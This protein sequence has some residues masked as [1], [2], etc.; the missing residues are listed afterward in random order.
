M[1]NIITNLIESIFT[2]PIT[3]LFLL[4][5]TL[6]SIFKIIENNKLYLFVGSKLE[7]IN[8][9]YK[10][11]VFYSKIRNDYYTYSKENPY[12]DV[13]ITS[14]VEEVVSDLKYNNL[15]ILEKIRSIKNSSSISILLGVLGT[16]VGLSTMLLCVDTKDIINS[17][18]S[19]ISSM[20]TAFTTSIFG[21]VFSLI[22]GYFTKIKDC[23]HV[24][25][26][27]ML[28]SENL[29]TSEVTHIKSERMDLKVEE[30]KNTIKQISKSIEAIEKFDKISKDLNDFNDEF[31]SGI[32]AL[33]SLLEGSQSSIKTFDQSVRKLDKQFNILNVKFVK[34]FDKYDNQD[35][36]N[37]EI[38]F[39]IKESSK[40]IYNSTESQHKIKDYIRNINAGFALYERSAQDLLTKLMTHENKISQNQKILLDEKYTLD[41]SIKNL[42]SIIENFSNDL[43][44]K[45]D[46]MFENS[47]D[48]QDKL[49]VMFNN[50]FMQD[51]VPL[52]SEDL[53]ENNIDSIFNPLSEEIY[54]IEK[55]EIKAIGEDELNE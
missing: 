29:L 37:K 44:T 10:T 48:I 45:L 28:K 4:A 2:N 46:I 15:P 51:E 23:E 3:I 36:I 41:D 31:I 7:E 1:S 33:K 27:I 9:D 13:N 16:F 47:L 19:T 42:S 49:D 5:I 20:Q 50:S 55:K 54:E 8:R 26:Q 24:L 18:P 22:I 12:A 11:S 38:L 21:V 6:Y 43:Q 53:F 35:N 39:D 25:I 40:N 32:E 14:F 30:V 34:L 17:L 52:D